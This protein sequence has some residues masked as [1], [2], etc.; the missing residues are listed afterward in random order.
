MY[1]VHMNFYIVDKKLQLSYGLKIVKG[2]RTKAPGT[3]AK[4]CLPP[5]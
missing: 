5:A 2:R 3:W 1:S 4:L